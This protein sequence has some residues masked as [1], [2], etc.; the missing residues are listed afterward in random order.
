M[1]DA[2]RLRLSR[3]ARFGHNEAMNTTELI[4]IRHGETVWNAEGRLQGH[5]DSPLTPLGHQQAMAIAT[6]LA[7]TAV[8]ALY[9]SDLGRA[10]ATAHYLAQTGGLTVTPEPGLR[11]RHNGVF[12]GMTLPEARAAHPA[13]YA[14]LARRDVDYTAPAGGESIRQA[15]ERACRV[16]S[17]VAARHAGE[18]IAVVS[19]GAILS[20]FLRRALGLPLD[21]QPRFSLRNACISC[22]TYSGVPDGWHVLSL[23]EVS[24]LEGLPQPYASGA[25]IRV[26]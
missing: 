4:L 17:E 11:E 1:S 3:H 14:R 20:A 22:V 13:E 25:H 15:S 6:R 10:L 2:G 5:Q 7:A 24:H 21:A 19:H 26:V 23:G 12:E 16:L 18:R 9:S 8:H